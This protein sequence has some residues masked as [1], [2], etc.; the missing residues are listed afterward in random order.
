MDRLDTSSNSFVQTQVPE[1]FECIPFIESIKKIL[2]NK[3]KRKKIFRDLGS[4]D[5]V[6][7][8]HVDGSDFKDHPF[9]KEERNV[10]HIL[11]YYDEFEV[12]NAL[13]SKTVI[14]KLGAFFFQILNHPSED[15]SELSSIHLLALCYADDME[16]EGAF[17]KVLTPF[18]LDMKKLSSPEGVMM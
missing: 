6:M 7:R 16:V 15:L 17:E 18:L 1:S 2:S 4:K 5:G 12:A 3:S 8:T 11:L 13:G 14:H 9:L 10:I